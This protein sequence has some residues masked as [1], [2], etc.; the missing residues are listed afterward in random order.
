MA[1]VLPDAAHSPAPRSD[2]LALLA[3]AVVS[4]AASYASLRLT[5][6]SGGVATIWVANGL[7]VGLLLLLPRTRWLAWLSVGLLGQAAARI[8]VG[9]APLVVAGLSLANLVEIVIV[10]GW[11]RRGGVEDLRQ[12]ASLGRLSRDGAAATI[13]ACVVSATLAA[14]V[15]P[16]TSPFRSLAKALVRSRSSALPRTMAPAR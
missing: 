16:A 8:L 6:F 4:V 13:V 14:L 15:R 12:A 3:L 1:A 9:D 2:V 11:L 5:R 7:L 10:V